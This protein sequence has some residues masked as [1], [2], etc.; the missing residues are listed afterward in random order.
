MGV[1][2]TLMTLSS[3]LRF[4]YTNMPREIGGNTVE[5]TLGI[6]FWC[7]LLATFLKLWD[8]IFNMIVPVPRHGFWGEGMDGE[9]HEVSCLFL[10]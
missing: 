9:I 7:T 1:V 4:C 5:Y 3:Y 10:C 6:S 8:F 2:T